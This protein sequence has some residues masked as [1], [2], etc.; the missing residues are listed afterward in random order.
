MGRSSQEQASRK[1][2]I[3]VKRASR[4]FREF[5]VENVSV[6]DVMKAAGMTVGGFYKH[7]SSK[8]ALVQEALGLAFEHAA[9]SWDQV[10]RTR[11]GDLEA[12]AGAIVEHYFTERPADETC[13]MLAFAPHVAVKAEWPGSQQ[14]YSKG[15][16]GLFRQFLDHRRGS[17]HAAYGPDDENEA[18][19][20]FAAMLGAQFL[21]RAAGDSE[22]VKSVQAAVLEAASAGSPVLPSGDSQPEVE[23]Q[24]DPD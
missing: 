6:A 18:K 24:D 3:I 14:V 12:S 9:S 11:V 8:E 23:V 15:V 7:F 19:V 16:E 2:E 22:W 5:G 21:S 4:L 13:P 1:R 10:S 20:L 17:S